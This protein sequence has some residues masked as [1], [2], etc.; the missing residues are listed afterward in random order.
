MRRVM[1]NRRQSFSL[2]QWEL[3]NKYLYTYFIC[4]SLPSGHRVVLN[5]IK[6][7]RFQQKFR[8]IGLLFLRLSLQ[9]KCILGGE[10]LFCKTKKLLQLFPVA[11]WIWFHA[12]PLF[13]LSS[14]SLTKLPQVPSSSRL[15]ISTPA[16]GASPLPA[17][18][19]IR[20]MHHI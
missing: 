15:E 12:A 13:P 9:K 2:R 8:P 1:Q 19:Y 11:S 4:S 16:P 6:K 14:F 10:M 17:A 3:Y 18:P 20:S 5:T 7:H